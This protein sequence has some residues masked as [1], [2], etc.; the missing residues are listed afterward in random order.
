MTDKNVVVIGSGLSGLSVA[1]ELA[2]F[3][4]LVEVRARPQTNV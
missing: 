1:L 2:Q 4:I 3:D